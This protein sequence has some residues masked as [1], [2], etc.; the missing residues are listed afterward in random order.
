[1]KV[2][3]LF[4][5]LIAPAAESRGEDKK[6]TLTLPSPASGSGFRRKVKAALITR[7]NPTLCSSIAPGETAN[8]SPW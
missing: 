3:F 2:F 6:K 7:P 4:L 1:M 8:S 5:A